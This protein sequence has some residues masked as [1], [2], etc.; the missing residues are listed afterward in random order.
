MVMYRKVH[1]Y[2]LSTGLHDL[3]KSRDF[4][5]LRK[6]LEEIYSIYNDLI[7]R[8]FED[9]QLF[10]FVYNK[11]FTYHRI[12]LEERMIKHGI[13]SNPVPGKITRRMPTGKALPRFR[14]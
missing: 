14:A 10:T 8:S 11:Y 4:E 6:K 9:M 13:L 3:M 7:D 5:G 2:E 12:L 1:M